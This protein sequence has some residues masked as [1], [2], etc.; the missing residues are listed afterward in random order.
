VYK[1]VFG[2]YLN[3]FTDF[4]AKVAEIPM[5]AFFGEMAVI[6]GSVRSATIISEGEGAAME[7]S[8]ENFKPLL[9]SNPVIAKKILATLATRYASTVKL[10]EE[11][12]NTV[13]ALPAEVASVEDIPDNACFDSMIFFASKIREL[14]QMLNP[15][16]KQKIE[17]KKSAG[18]AVRLLPDGHEKLSGEDDNNNRELLS[19]YSYSCP[20]CEYNFNGKIPLISRLLQKEKTPDFRAAYSNFNIFYYTNVVCPNCNYCD[21]YQEFTKNIFIGV[22]NLSGIQF[23]NEELFTGFTDDYA[24]TAEEALLS[25]Y[26]NLECLKQIS[27][28]ELRIGKTW[29]RLFWFYSDTGNEK[30]KRHAAEQAVKN[31]HAHLKNNGSDMKVE[32][33]MTLNMITAELC[34]VIDKHA[35]AM[36][37]FKANTAIPRYTG[38]ELAIISARRFRE[39]KSE[40][41]A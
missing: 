1:G 23:P 12:G 21:C 15:E 41:G 17:V 29:Q 5:G 18:G 13:E 9:A 19:N 30:W 32:E 3:T 14:N 6:D 39:I 8:K 20:Y 40:V 38:H 33:Y 4:P 16:L 26:L 35:E 36:E 22:D 25:H 7:I 28:A 10:A 37:Y 27:G 34:C 2:V 24:R 31:F 11:A